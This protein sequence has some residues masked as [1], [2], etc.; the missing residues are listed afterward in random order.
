LK[1]AVL[2]VGGN[3]LLKEGQKETIDEQF[4]TAKETCQHITKMIMDGWH[5]ALTHGNGP[6][7]GHILRRV[8]LSSHELSTQGYTL[9]ICGAES[10]GLIGYILQQTLDICMT[11][12]GFCPPKQIVTV[13]TQVIVDEDDPAFKNPTKPIGSFYDRETARML[14]KR[15]KWVM[16]EG[17]KG[18]W[19]RVVASPDPLEIIELQII[20]KLINE[21]I[22]VICVGGGG[23]P[24]SR[25]KE[26][27]HLR[28][29]DQAVIDK[30]L[31]SSLLACKIDADLFLIATAVEKVALN[32]GKPNQQ[33]LE[34][35]SVEEA[36][37]YLAEGHFLPGSMAPKITAAIRFL[38]AGGKKVII[39][40]LEKIGEALKG[41][42][43]TLI[44]A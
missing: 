42:T 9:D 2:A 22:I 24:V 44:T 23:I 8:E 1:K 33:W 26:N 25:D 37:K 36:K 21:G 11:A 19:R 28:G 31:A 39:T 10:Q 43:G 32:F 6:Q 16:R 7:I 5:I 20:K 3:A 34:S 30:D 14:M 4:A 27:G 41:E 12:C 13:L 38:E 29:I 17:T 40:S 35:I 18:K 15:E